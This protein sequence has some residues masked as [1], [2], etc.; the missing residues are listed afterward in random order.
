MGLIRK[1][2]FWPVILLILLIA[3][4]LWNGGDKLRWFGQKS[5]ETGKAIQEKSEEVGETSDRLKKTIEEKK[6]VV[7]EKIEGVVDTAKKHGIIKREPLE[8]KK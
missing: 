5:A 8:E 2:V 1:V 7:G 6:E 4:I 3:F